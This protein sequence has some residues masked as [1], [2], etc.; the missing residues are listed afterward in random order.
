MLVLHKARPG[1]RGCKGIGVFSVRWGAESPAFGFTAA[2]CK[3]WVTRRGLTDHNTCIEKGWGMSRI[4][5]WFP[6]PGRW[7]CYEE[8]L[9]LGGLSTVPMLELCQGL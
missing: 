3:L 8:Q 2:C 6:G 4:K 5:G 7:S 1:G 9:H